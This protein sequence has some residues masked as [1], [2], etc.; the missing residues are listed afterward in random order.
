VQITGWTFAPTEALAESRLALHAAA[1]LSAGKE[2]RATT[3][4]VSCLVALVRA[5]KE[6]FIL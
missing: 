3:G 1:T 5:D 6:A 4:R 2:G